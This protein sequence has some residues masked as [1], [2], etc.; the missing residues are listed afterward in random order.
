[1]LAFLIDII[2]GIIT[3]IVLLSQKSL[4]A[5]MLSSEFWNPLSRLSWNII[6]V[7]VLEELFTSFRG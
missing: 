3:N 4:P 7:A 6:F 2:N 1:M 5:L